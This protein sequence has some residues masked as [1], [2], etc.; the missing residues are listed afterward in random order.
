M[1][2]S[3]YSAPQQCV[4]VQTHN[5]FCQLAYNVFEV[6]DSKN[7]RFERQGEAFKVS[8][9]IKRRCK[10]ALTIVALVCHQR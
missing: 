9:A 5:M 6:I 2:Q 7:D 10:T 8:E 1:L 4:H 3:Q